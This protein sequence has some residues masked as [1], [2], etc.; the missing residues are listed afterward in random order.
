MA[1]TQAADWSAR[2][3]APADALWA[4]R[5]EVWLAA[6]AAGLLVV[7]LAGRASDREAADRHRWRH[8]S[9]FLLEARFSGLPVRFLYQLGVLYTVRRR[10]RR[11]GFH[12]PARNWPDD[13]VKKTEQEPPPAR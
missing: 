9:H 13:L 10:A 8:S 2:S 1:W 11:E 4:R 5:L 7:L 12:T 6:P 3:A